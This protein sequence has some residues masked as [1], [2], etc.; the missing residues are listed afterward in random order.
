MVE[1]LVVFENTTTSIIK[2]DANLKTDPK[3][4]K[5]FRGQLY[6]EESIWQVQNLGVSEKIL[7]KDWGRLKLNSAKNKRVAKYTRRARLDG[8]AP[9]EEHRKLKPWRY[10]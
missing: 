9:R 8:H 5:L 3:K 7:E 2:V 10:V 6:G 1:D 4:K